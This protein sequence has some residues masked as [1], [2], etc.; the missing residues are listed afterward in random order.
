MTWW[1]WDSKG[2][3]VS[4]CLWLDSFKEWISSITYF[5]Y[6]TGFISTVRSG[7][8]SG[9]GPRAVTNDQVSAE[10]IF[11]YTNATLMHTTAYCCC[12]SDDTVVNWSCLII[13]SLALLKSSPASFPKP[14][15]IIVT[16]FQ[17]RPQERCVFAGLQYFWGGTRCQC[18]EVP[19][20][21]P[22]EITKSDTP[23]GTDGSWDRK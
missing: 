13:F 4:E 1:S 6:V 23:S 8:D 5:T 7:W 21:I 14:T 11:H 3:L 19:L 22:R 16:C 10:D 20:Y 15:D 12:V 17:V 2:A 9:L 18:V